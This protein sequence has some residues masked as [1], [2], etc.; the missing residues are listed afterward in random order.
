MNRSARIISLVAV[1]VKLSALD[2][3]AHLIG[4]P[5]H[6]GYVLA[7]KVPSTNV[8]QNLYT[9]PAGN[10]TLMATFFAP[11]RPNVRF[12]WDSA[13]FYAESD[14]FPDRFL[15]PNPMVGIT[16]W[17]QQIPLPVSFF[18]YTTNPEKDT[19]SLGYNQPNVW[20][21][22]LVPV[23]AAPPIPLSSNNFQRGAVALGVNGIPIFNPRNNRGEF[24]YDIGELD[25][26]GG[27]CGLADDYHYH[28]AP[29]HLQN[30][31][32]PTNPVAWALD[33]YPI[34]GYTEP[35]GSPRQPLDADGGHA[36]VTGNYH[37]HAIGSVATGPQ[38]PY[39]MNAM[40]G[41][42][43]NYGGQ[44]DPQPEV[45]SIRRTGTGGYNAKA[46]AG[47]AI[48]AFK[49]PVA[50]ATNVTGDFIEDTNGVPSPDQFLMRYSFG[51]TNYDCCW[52]LNRDPNPKTL[53]VTWRA[54]GTNASG[55]LA[56]PVV[57][58]TTTYANNN[59]RLTAYPMAALSL[60]KLPDT[61]VTNVSGAAFGQ[62]ADYTVHPPAF[63]DNGD[64]TITDHITGLMWQKTDNGESTWESAVTNARRVTTGGYTDWRLPTPTEL[65][66]IANHN[67]NPALDLNYFPNHPSG[68]AE[69]WWTTDIYGT[70]AANVW[71]MNKGGGL[72]PKPKNETLSA[73]GAFRYHARYV[74][75]GKPSNGHNYL[76]NGDGTVTDLDTGLMWQQVPFAATNW[77]AALTNAE[78]LSLGGYT[79]WRLPNIKELQ[80]LTDYPLATATTASSARACVNRVLFP[81]NTTPATAYWSSTPLKSG[82]PNRVWLLELGV[83]TTVPAANGP[84]RGAQGI[85][86]YETNATSYPFFCV[87]GPDQQ[88][89]LAQPTVVS[90]SVVVSW[91]ASPGRTYTVYFS[92][93][94]N[95]ATWTN[96]GSLRC[97]TT[98][99]F[100]A[101]TNALPATG[102]YRVGYVP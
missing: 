50:L 4:D 66:S 80:T 32:G 21:F 3:A 29:L 60:L 64:S 45:G 9:P 70:N 13:S 88:F 51:G 65:F 69:Y 52:R 38:N 54:Q 86:S 22:P 93:S 99:G 56:G 85:I 95:S 33:G 27:H 2:G 89:I 39:L 44:I 97:M 7:G 71:C 19:N 91:P 18:A 12:Y 23:P 49:N 35:D 15:M 53:T 73:G 30:V 40:H 58:T 37:Y 96:V 46:I 81:T 78:T 11:F 31:V 17:Q 102:F 101:V 90:N 34:Y 26:Y 61:G 20:K 62:D 98:T 6:D 79:D 94:L 55:Q 67:N 48:V 57:T 16:A 87:R 76:N 84:P 41:T 77:T 47:A 82:T 8:V 72:G 25:Q 75:G 24:S 83:N 5:A 63:T 1:A 28:I 92:P 74:R 36:A 68:A 59:N 14:G 100:F 43:V 42:V 10:G